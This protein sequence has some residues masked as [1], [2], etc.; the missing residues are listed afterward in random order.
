MQDFELAL[1]FAVVRSSSGPLPKCVS[2]AVGQFTS[3][4]PA[5]FVQIANTREIAVGLQRIFNRSSVVPNLVAIFL[6]LSAFRLAR[7]HI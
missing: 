7:K 4:S 6:L 1:C 5:G 2:A 3:G